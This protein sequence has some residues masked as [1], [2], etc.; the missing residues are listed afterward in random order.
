M[1]HCIVAESTIELLLLCISVY[2]DHTMR[3]GDHFPDQ[4]KLR[5]SEKKGHY[6]IEF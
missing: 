4:G 2:N 6:L 5:I 1:F 3:Q